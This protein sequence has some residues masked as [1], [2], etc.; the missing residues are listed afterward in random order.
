M[1]GSKALMGDL[2]GI[3]KFIFI[4]SFICVLFI[5]GRVIYFK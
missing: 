4:S 1:F 2:T 5:K 3:K